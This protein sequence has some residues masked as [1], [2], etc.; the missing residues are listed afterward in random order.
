M[1]T[2]ISAVEKLSIKKLYSYN[3]EDEL[4]QYVHDE[5]IEHILEGVHNT[6][7]H[8]LQLG[9]SLDGLQRAEDPKH[10]ERLDGA[11]VL[12]CSTAPV[13]T[14][15]DACEWMFLGRCIGEAVLVDCCL[16]AS[17]VRTRDKLLQWGSILNFWVAKG[18]Y[19]T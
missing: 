12:A 15:T 19:S 16:N 1:H 2:L 5:D 9:H 7:K 18:E 11:E 3:S 13:Y 8:R 10:S 6:V 14:Q 17:W 4:K